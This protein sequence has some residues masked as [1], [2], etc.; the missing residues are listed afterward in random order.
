MAQ[1]FAD[2]GAQGAFGGGSG[3]APAPTSGGTPPSTSSQGSLTPQGNFTLDNASGEQ[4]FSGPNGPTEP[5]ATTNQQAVDE[6]AQEAFNNITG[7]QSSS[8]NN[9]FSSGGLSGGGFAFDQGGAVPD[10]DNG[11]SDGSPGQN[12][13]A[14]ALE[15]VDKTLQYSYQKYGLT[16]GD[17]ETGGGQQTAGMMPTIPGNQSNT[18]GPYVPQQPQPRQQGAIDTDEDAA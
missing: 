9:D 12:S 17:N 18:P 10:D 6:E 15:S 14:Q 2:D 8:S 7:N 13:M 4:I 1:S 5:T 11:D 3:P 16:G